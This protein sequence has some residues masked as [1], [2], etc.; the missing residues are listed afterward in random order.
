MEK[1]Q[2]YTIALIY[3]M[4]FIVGALGL[5]AGILWFGIYCIEKLIKQLKLWQVL[6]EFIWE[7]SRKKYDSNN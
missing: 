1:I 5:I 3:Y 6:I 2:H 4:I 7:R